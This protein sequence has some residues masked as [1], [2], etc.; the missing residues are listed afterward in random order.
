[1]ADQQH[2]IDDKITFGELIRRGAGWIKIFRKKWRVL[3]YGLC[4]GGIL[5]LIASWIKDPVYTAET[6]FVIEESGSSGMGGLSGLANLAGVNLGSLGSRSGLF[7][8]DNIMELYRSESMLSTT[9]LSPF[10]G[11]NDSVQLLVERYVA[12]HKLPQKWGDEVDFSQL[13]F[14]QPRAEFSVEQDS[15]IKEIVKVIRKENLA[16]SKPDRKLS[17]IKVMVKS[18]DEAFAKVFNEQLVE[19]VNQFYYETKTKKTAENLEVLQHQ[20]DSVRKILDK[21]L[22]TYA[23]MQD[24]R[25]NPNPLM[26]SLTVEAQSKEVDIEV[27]ATA[28]GEI[29]KNLEIAKIN[30]RNSSPLIQVV[31]SPRYPLTESKLKWYVALVIGGVLGFFLAAVYIYISRLYQA[32]I[33]GEQG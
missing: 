15:V 11:R 1:M 4:L 14:H 33:K 17:I 13:N 25:P 28:Y 20:A 27:T 18:K 3:F 7:Q 31:D 22:K 29:I 2:I 9:L 19:N 32:N 12:F 5:G 6:T 8:G 10:K 16:V 23:G 30:H 26:Q 24:Q 21:N